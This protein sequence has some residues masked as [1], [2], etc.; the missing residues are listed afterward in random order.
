MATPEMLPQAKSTRKFSIISSQLIILN[1]KNNMNSLIK[2]TFHLLLLHL[3]ISIQMF[4]H[5]QLLLFLSTLLLLRSQ[6]IGRSPLSL[7]D[8]Q[9]TFC[10]IRMN[11]NNKTYSMSLSKTFLAANNQLFACFRK[12][13]VSRLTNNECELT[14]S[15]NTTHNYN[16]LGISYNK[17]NP[18]NSTVSNYYSD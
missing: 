11:V 7:C 9:D 4:A 2:L 3:H 6:N 1:T 16:C 12:R 17:E 13:Q 14:S 10:D 5:K 18:A 15:E 8:N